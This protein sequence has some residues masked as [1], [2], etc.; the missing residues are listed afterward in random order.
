M[1]PQIRSIDSIVG[2]QFGRWS[3]R[4]QPGK[5]PQKIPPPVITISR[6][7]G[8]FGKL[9]AR[10]LAEDLNMDLSGKN[11]IDQVAQNAKVSSAVVRTID[12]KDRS[13]L[14][15]LIATWQEKSNISNDTYF[16]HLVRIIGTIGKHGNHIIVGRG[17]NFI[18]KPPQN[19]RIRFIAPLEMRVD[20]LMKEY[21]LALDDA[22]K[23]V[24]ESDAN[25]RAYIRKYFHADIDDPSNY[26]LVINNAYVTIEQSVGIIK[27]A[28]KVRI[29]GR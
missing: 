12:E 13:F 19:L 21:G 9:V 29:A 5:E 22:V 24:K 3:A 20:S 1:R 6:E 10:R 28:V 7:T 14:D 4:D 17:A 16:D 15:D 8:S 2:E 23:K 26:D 11:I 27:E 25:R 18:I